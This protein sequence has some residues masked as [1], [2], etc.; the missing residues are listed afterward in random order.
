M[1]SS[2]WPAATAEFEKMLIRCQA[3]SRVF[4]VLPPTLQE[5][6][7]I[8]TL[9]GEIKVNSSSS[10][11]ILLSLTSL[12]GALEYAAAAHTGSIE[13]AAEGL[14]KFFFQALFWK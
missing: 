4:A 14:N 2:T 13:T 7:R 5:V 8:H 9:R 10:A 1:T 3:E 6:I 11:G 12:H